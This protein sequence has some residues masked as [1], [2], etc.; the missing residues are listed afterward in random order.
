MQK[1]THANPVLIF[2]QNKNNKNRSMRKIASY[3]ILK[4]YF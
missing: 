3:L 1:I 2:C 4:N